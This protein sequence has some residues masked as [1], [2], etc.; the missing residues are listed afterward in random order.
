MDL[1]LQPSLETARLL[2]RPFAPEDAPAVERLVS[3][4][5]IARG[6][7]RIPHPYPEGGAEAWIAPQ[8]EAWQKGEAAVFAICRKESGGVV[9]AVGLHPEAVHAR[10][11]LGYWIGRPYWR[12]GYATEA[13]R[14][15]VAFGCDTLGLH[16]IFAGVFSPKAASAAVLTKCGFRHEGRQGG[17]AVHFGE[18]LDF[19]LYGLLRA[20]WK[21]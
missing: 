21:A 16:R 10:A 14:A 19:D 13:V 9:G 11:E 12:Q 18:R 20:E 1:G 2:L 8:A 17:H 4:V 6:A 3:N 7:A 5:E 15:V